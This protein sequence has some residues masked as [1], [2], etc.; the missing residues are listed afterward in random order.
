MFS[1]PSYKS[2]LEQIL[3][4]LLL[5]IVISIYFVLYFFYNQASNTI[6]LI[7]FFQE[8]TIHFHDVHEGVSFKW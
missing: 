6:L 3:F 1:A 7:A 2:F 5:H 4:I 8:S